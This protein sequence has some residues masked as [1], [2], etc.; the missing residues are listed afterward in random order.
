MPQVTDR[1]DRCLS[2]I[3]AIV[4]EVESGKYVNCAL[5]SKCIPECSSLSTAALNDDRDA[6]FLVIC[7]C[8][9]TRDGAMPMDKLSPAN[10]SGY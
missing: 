6:A 2:I 3:I 7:S 4:L 1:Q 10:C 8:Q 5:L 9:A